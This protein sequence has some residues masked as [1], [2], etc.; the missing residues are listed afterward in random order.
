MEIFIII[1]VA[2][3]ILVV[4]TEHNIT[5]VTCPPTDYNY[6]ELKKELESLNATLKELESKLG[7]K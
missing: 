4:Y 5:G 1:L 2:A 3:L 6:E 7:E